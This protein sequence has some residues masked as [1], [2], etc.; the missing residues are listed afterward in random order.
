MKIVHDSILAGKA[1]S[2]LERDAVR[3]VKLLTEKQLRIAV[4]ESCTGGL[5]GSLLAVVPGA[6]EVFWGGFICYTIDAKQ[7]MLGIDAALL[8]HYG[9]VSAECACAMAA[10]ARERAEADLSLSVTGLAGPD[11]DGSANPVGTVWLGASYRGAPPSANVHHFTGSRNEIR[12]R[13][14]AAA[15]MLGIDLASK[16]KPV[17]FRG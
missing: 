17:C 5:V 16:A 13:A 12:A 7:K 6:S 15:L 14:A 2:A 8:E 3:L 10:S 4:A 1:A 11:G 9:A